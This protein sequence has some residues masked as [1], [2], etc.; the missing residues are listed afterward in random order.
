MLN[1]TKNAIIDK[2][3]TMDAKSLCCAANAYLDIGWSILPI[4]GKQ[5]AISSWKKY[6]RMRPTIAEVNDW[7]NG[8]TPKPSGVAVVTGQISRLVVVDCDAAEAAELWTAAHP[9]SPLVARTGRGG[10]HIYY[11]APA[12]PVRNRVKIGQ[13]AIDIRGEGGYVVAPPSMHDTGV[14][15]AWHSPDGDMIPTLPRFESNWLSEYEPKPITPHG[16]SDVRPLRNAAAYI[17]RIHA[18]AGDGGHSATFRAA[19]KLR[20]SGI[21]A[22]DALILL[23]Q[24]NESN[25]HPPWSAAELAHKIQS[26]YQVEQGEGTD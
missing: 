22:D 26:A 6:Q 3:I 23:T 1:Q 19:C 20:D 7:F 2:I 16:P 9:P 10:M 13:H 11:S 25:A 17:A 8:R 24:W 21:T 14:A 4:C 15:Y 12:E 18:H 5:P